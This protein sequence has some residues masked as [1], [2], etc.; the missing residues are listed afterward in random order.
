[1]LQSV[2]CVFVIKPP[3]MNVPATSHNC[4]FRILSYREFNNHCGFKFQKV[5]RLQSKIQKDTA[6]SDNGA[7]V[8]KSS[9]EAVCV[10]S[11]ISVLQQ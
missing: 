5:C 10:P 9:A 4:P 6:R 7:R 2:L 8:L 11:S 3:R 1:M